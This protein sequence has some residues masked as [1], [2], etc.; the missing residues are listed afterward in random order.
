MQVLPEDTYY[1]HDIEDSDVYIDVEFF[2]KLKE[3][4]RMPHND[5]YLVRKDDGKE[6]MIPAVEEFVKIIDQENKKVILY[7]KCKMFD[8]YEN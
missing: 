6:V 1:I 5:V 8:E 4:L 7:S 2:G 3:V